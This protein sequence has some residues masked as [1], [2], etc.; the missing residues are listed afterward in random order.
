MDNCYRSRVPKIS[1]PYSILAHVSV[2]MIKDSVQQVLALH[3]SCVYPKSRVCSDIA[4]KFPRYFLRF[5]T[6]ENLI[7][8]LIVNIFIFGSNL[9]VSLGWTSSNVSQ[10]RCLPWVVSFETMT[11]IL[12]S[13]L[14]R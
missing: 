8:V 4:Y 10:R 1:L 11:G 9:T 7:L 14:E 2:K 13:A 12:F 3:R 6:I 5:A